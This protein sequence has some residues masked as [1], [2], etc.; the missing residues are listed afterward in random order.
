MIITLCVK[1]VTLCGYKMYYIMRKSY[2]VMHKFITLCEKVITLCGNYYIMRKLL[3]YA[4]SQSSLSTLT[5]REQC[6]SM[7][8]HRSHLKYAAASNKARPCSDALWDFWPVAK[9]CLRHNNRR[10]LPPYPI[11]WQ[12]L[13]PRPSQSQYKGTQGYHQGHA[14]C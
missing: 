5:R 13:Q 4:A 11:R 10:N 3:R 12:A 14:V 9:T 6:S 8:A 7:T 1:C 2:Y